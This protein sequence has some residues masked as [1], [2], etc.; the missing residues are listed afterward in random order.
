MPTAEPIPNPTARLRAALRPAI[1]LAALTVGLGLLAAPPAGAADASGAASESH[2]EQFLDRSQDDAGRKR[3]DDERDRGAHDHKAY[4]YHRDHAYRVRAGELVPGADRYGEPQ[5]SPPVVPALKGDKVVGYVYL[6]SDVVNTTGY[7]GKPIRTLVGLSPDGTIVGARLVEHH[8]PIV[9]IGIPEKRIAAYLDGFLGFNPLRAVAHGEAAPEV[10]IV[11]G[12]TVTVLVIG[13]GVVRSAGRIAAR[14]LGGTEAAAA[15]A[16]PKRVVDPEGGTVADW[17]SLLGNGAVRRLQVTVA[18]VNE[19]FERSG[20]A[21]AAKRPEKGKPDATFVDLYVA[22]ASQPA[23]GRS[24][25]GDEEYERLRQRLAPGQAAVLVM[26]R[27][28]Y[29]FKGSG[30]VRG[31][32]FDRIEVTQGAETVR[33]R[34]KQHER[35]A[36]LAA[37]GAPDFKEIALFTVPQGAQLDPAETWTLRLLVQR[38]IGALDKAFTSFALDYRLPAPYAKTVATVAPAARPADTAAAQAAAQAASGAASAAATFAGAPETPLWQRIWHSKVVSIGVLVAMLLVLTAIFFFQDLLV[39]RERLFF[40]LRIGFL[41]VT[42]FW[43]GWVAEAQLSVVNVLA[44]ANALRTDFQWSY[45]L[46]DPLIFILWFSVA[47]ALLFWGRGPFCGW[48]CPFGALQELTNRVARALKLPQVKVPWGLHE[49]LWPIKYIVFLGL[50]GV[51]LTSL[52]L[53]EQLAEIEPFKTAIILH[54][55]RDWWFVAFALALIVAGLFVERFFCRYLCPLGA[56]LAIPGRLRMFDWLKRYRECGSPCMRCFNECPVQAIHPEGHI[57]P[58]E[59][60]SCLHCQV[61]YRHDRKCPVVIQKRLKRERRAATAAPSTAAPDVAL[62][63]RP[64][65]SDRKNEAPAEPASQS[66][67]A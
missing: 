9:L 1:L 35:I 43:L 46:V 58:N 60:I 3:Q 63:P 54:F 22:L 48:L 59:C 33:F 24:L 51:S 7:S 50:F 31:G 15:P 52:G 6:T 67:E 28:R 34:D 62:P 17:T 47:A 26:G 19:A 42:L 49:R 4:G 38:R 45:F 40:W 37:A 44:F 23:I 2:L 20:N 66:T 14:L 41:T 5:G 12:A 55:V 8:E 27:G 56:A 64:R 16:A 32:V 57:N 39:K 10:D 30:Y 61:L 25:L 21:E 18:G 36:E 13:D 29:S 53:A 65:L 11:S